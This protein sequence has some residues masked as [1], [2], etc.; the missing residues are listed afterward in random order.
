MPVAPPSGHWCAALLRTSVTVGV[1]DPE[2]STVLRKSPELAIFRGF[3]VKPIKWIVQS[4]HFVW[5]HIRKPLVWFCAADMKQK[6]SDELQSGRFWGWRFTRLMLQP[7]VEEQSAETSAGHEENSMFN[8]SCRAN[9]D[10]W[11]IFRFPLKTAE[12]SHCVWGAGK[13]TVCTFLCV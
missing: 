10:Y 13:L 9:A 11:S 2:Q 1:T 5:K 8:N 7:R 3:F 6:F 12:M 4:T